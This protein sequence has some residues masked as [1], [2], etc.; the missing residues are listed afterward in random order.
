MINNFI[1][2]SKLIT[3]YLLCFGALCGVS[4]VLTHYAVKPKQVKKVIRM[5]N[6]IGYK[7]AV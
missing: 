6:G 5:Y 7:K 1:L 2:V 3:V 4:G